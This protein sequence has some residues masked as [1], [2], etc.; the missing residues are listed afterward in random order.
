MSDDSSSSSGAPKQQLLGAGGPRILWAEDDIVTREWVAACF[1]RNGWDFVAVPDGG[2]ALNSFRSQGAFDL[3]LTDYRM[4]GMD[5]LDLIRAIRKENPEQ[6]IVVVTGSGSVNEVLE[7]LYSGASSVLQKPIDLES[8][9]RVIKQFSDS[10]RGREKSDLFFRFCGE[11][12]SRFELTPRDFE[13]CTFMLP[14]SEQLF[15]AKLISRRQ[16]LEIDLAFNEIIVNAVDHGC[17]E[18]DSALREQFDQGGLDKYSVLKAQRMADPQFADRKVTVTS[19][20]KTGEIKVTVRDQGKGFPFSLE[21]KPQAKVEQVH[22][23]G[24]SLV[25]ALVDEFAF[26][27]GRP[28]IWFRKKF[29]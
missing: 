24:L 26:E 20:Y 14:A 29:S 25:A 10:V 21:K 16:K 28:E 7:M 2:S 17:L 12:I 4:P 15:R 9:Q 22:G 18:L 1:V 3:V 8:L 5:G 27:K 23:R 6:P 13:A 19:E 11:E